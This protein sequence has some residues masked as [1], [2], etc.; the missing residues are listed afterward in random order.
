MKISNGITTNVAGNLIV[1]H[2]LSIGEGLPM[3]S[4]AV[5]EAHFIIVNKGTIT[6]TYSTN[7]VQPGTS[8]NIFFF[9][10]DIEH[11]I[12]AIAD[13]TVI[14]NITPGYYTNA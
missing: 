11:E 4:H 2:N 6:I 8:G 9:P 14:T 10:I 1:S 12:V 7:V 13:G 3:H 5:G